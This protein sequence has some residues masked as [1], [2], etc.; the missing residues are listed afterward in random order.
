M[1]DFS[2][3]FVAG[4]TCAFL[5]FFVLKAISWFLE[6]YVLTENWYGFSLKFMCVVA[7][8]SNIIP[9]QIFMKQGRAEA[10][11]GVM[12]ATFMLVF[13]VAIYFWDVFMKG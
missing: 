4:I 1:R 6:S 7:V 10:V 8:V 3:G 13:G 5:F 2:N 9:F 12:A 11:R